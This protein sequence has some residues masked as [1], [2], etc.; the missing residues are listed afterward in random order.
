[1]YCDTCQAVVKYTSNYHVIGET[2]IKIF[3]GMMKAT[4]Q[5]LYSFLR[6]S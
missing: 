1:M 2:V 5:P 6:D 4:P 3:F